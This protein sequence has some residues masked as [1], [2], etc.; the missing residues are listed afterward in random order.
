MAKDY[1]DGKT[2]KVVEEIW[3][4]TDKQLRKGV[5]A[6]YG[7]TG[8]DV[9]D[10]DTV[11]QLNENVGVFSAFKS[12]RMN[13]EMKTNLTD[14]KGNKRSFDEF[15]KEY[16][17]VDSKYNINYLRA[18]YNIAQKQ[19]A[20]ANQWQDFKRDSNLYPNL[21][22][23]PSRSAEPRESH[24][25]Y[26][27]VIKPI[28]DAFWDTA[29]PP[30]DWGCSCWVTNTDEGADDRAVEA[31]LPID[32]VSG[33]AGKSGQVYSKKHPYVADVPKPEKKK[34]ESFS[35]AMAEKHLNDQFV[36]SKVGKGKVKL[37]LTH[38]KQGMKERL[39]FA[40]NATMDNGKTFELK[41]A[42]SVPFRYNKVDGDLS[43]FAKKTKLFDKY[44]KGKSLEKLK[45]SFLGI[46]ISGKLSRN[47]LKGI[48]QNILTGFTDN[49]AC[50]FVIVRNDKKTTIMQRD[51]SL[52]G[53][54]NQISKDLM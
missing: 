5:T 44:D 8:Y 49:K 41:G 48:A 40:Y 54:V 2:D 15:L 13:N 19:S 21:K 43:T 25:Q 3:K 45:S 1:F 47:N 38:P 34:V 26:Y 4:E 6:G 28:D 32:G 14:D 10:F 16:N 53:I 22:Y 11:K 9:Q 33:N 46:E 17:K 27:G 20:A 7:T 29:T 39:D 42:N 37:S 51:L 18:E 30:L 50:K 31:P 36:E 23:M 35:N 52:D 24:K 12:Y